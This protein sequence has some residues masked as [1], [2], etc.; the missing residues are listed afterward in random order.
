MTTPP[1]AGSLRR[2]ASGTLRGTS[3]RARAE[4][5]EKITGASDTRSAS[6]MVVRRDVG[7]V[8]QHAQ[9]VHLPDHLLAE[10]G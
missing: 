8:H 9:A 2:T 10:R 4:E 5:W 6:S 3:V 1:F 7:E